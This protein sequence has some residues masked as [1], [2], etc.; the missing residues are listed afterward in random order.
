MMTICR[1]GRRAP[2]LVT[3]FIKS[4]QDDD[5]FVIWFVYLRFDEEYKLNSYIDS[6]GLAI[7]LVY[8]FFNLAFH[9]SPTEIIVN[10]LF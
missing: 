2:D 3:K 6:L 10:K 9:K 7:S 8:H 4:V 1:K 5:V